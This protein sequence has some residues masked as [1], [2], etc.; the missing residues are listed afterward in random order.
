MN[1]FW[2]FLGFLQI[3]CLIKAKTELFGRQEPVQGDYPYAEPDHSGVSSHAFSQSFL[4]GQSC[5]CPGE[6]F[7]RIFDIEDIATVNGIA[8]KE[9]FN[10]FRDVWFARGLVS[11]I[12]WWMWYGYTMIILM[13]GITS[14]SRRL[15]LLHIHVAVYHFWYYHGQHKRVKMSKNVYSLFL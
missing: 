9:A 3:F 14:G 4:M 5:Q 6:S 15:Y 1:F 7:F 8:V 12:Q 2:H 10:F 11:F 13:A